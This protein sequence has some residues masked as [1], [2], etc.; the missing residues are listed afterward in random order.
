MFLFLPLILASSA[1]LAKSAKPA[2]TI[3]SDPTNEVQLCQGRD[4]LTCQKIDVHFD[5]IKSG[6]SI[7]IP[8]VEKLMSSTGDIEDSS[9]S[10]IYT[11]SVS[12]KRWSTPVQ[13]IAQLLMKRP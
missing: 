10:K 11:Y 8:G 5:V 9:Y 4:V 6:G 12:Q 7:L 2:F 13:N 1:A 3:L